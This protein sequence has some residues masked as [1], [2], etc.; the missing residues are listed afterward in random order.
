MARM[1][2]VE[3]S[4]LI[5]ALSED[6]KKISEIKPPHWSAFAKTGAHKERPPVNNDWWYVRAAAILRSVYKLGPVGVQ[7]L[8]RKYGGK[9]NRGVVAER[10]YKGSGSIARKILQQ[11]EKAGLVT[12]TAKGVHKG[13]VATGKG[14]SL[15]DKAALRIGGKPDKKSIKEKKT[16][17][18]K[19]AATAAEKNKEKVATATAE[20]KEEVKA[21]HNKQQKK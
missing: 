4:K 3:Q 6:L 12:H 19:S 20:K 18:E 8:R 21:T 13:R 5:E 15:L 17:K 1:F 2:D 10:F 7:K 14:Q 9:R 16:V 11:L